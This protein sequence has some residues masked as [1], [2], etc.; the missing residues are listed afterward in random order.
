[1]VPPSAT[2][3]R[4]GVA[5]VVA[6]A[7]VSLTV[8]AA[9]AQ[10]PPS[11]SSGI[12]QYVE[13]LPT[14]GGTTTVVAE[15]EEPAPL[16][17]KVKKAIVRKGGSDAEAL[18]RLVTPPAPP[19]P[20]PALESSPVPPPRP[21]RAP[22]PKPKPEVQREQRELVHRP[23]LPPVSTKSVSAAF[24]S[25]TGDT[26]EHVLALLIGLPLLTFAAAALAFRRRRT[27]G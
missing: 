24:D 6:A 8:P 7:S 2:S 21:Q 27:N 1:M 12:S 13:Q 23:D 19:P 3:A 10:D 20:P 4:L 25:A 9:S 18:T 14:A 5:L 17:P 22:R 26:D 16:P 11:P 15:P